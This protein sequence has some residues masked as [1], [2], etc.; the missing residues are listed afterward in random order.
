MAHFAKVNDLGIIEELIV[1]D[2]QDILTKDGKESETLG[3]RFI[4]SLGLSGKWVQT[5][6]NGNPINGFDRG[7][8]AIV[9]GTWDGSKFSQLAK[10][11]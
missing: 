7:A 8:C 9:G 4:K 11:E 2:N 6:Y 3:Q 5:S 10:S 1:I